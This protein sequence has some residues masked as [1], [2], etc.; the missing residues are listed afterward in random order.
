MFFE[1]IFLKILSFFLLS[2]IAIIIWDVIVLDLLIEKIFSLILVFFLLAFWLLLNGLE[3]LPLIILLLYVGAIAV[4]CLFVVILLNQKLQLRSYLTQ[5]HSMLKTLLSAELNFNFLYINFSSE[6]CYWYVDDS[7]DEPGQFL[8]NSA[9]HRCLDDAKFTNFRNNYL[10]DAEVREVFQFF[11]ST[12]DLEKLS[13]WVDLNNVTNCHGIYTGD[14]FFMCIGLGI[15]CGTLLFSSVYL[16]F[17]VLQEIVNG[18]LVTTEDISSTT[19]M[20]TILDHNIQVVRSENQWFSMDIEQVMV[21]R[22]QSLVNVV[23]LENIHTSLIT[24]P[25]YFHQMY[26]DNRTIFRGNMFEYSNQSSVMDYH[27]FRI[28]IQRLSLGQYHRVSHDFMRQITASEIHTNADHY[29]YQNLVASFSAGNEEAKEEFE[30]IPGR[31]RPMNLYFRSDF[32][33]IYF[34][35]IENVANVNNH[36]MLSIPIED[37]LDNRYYAGRFGRRSG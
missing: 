28:N 12:N 7:T 14:I 17:P 11:W 22:E 21:P 33:K 37:P 3:G 26:T 5:Q 34:F 1:L 36:A 31:F 8:C 24:N 19:N 13:L 4:L 9:L 29:E 6:K 18:N 20:V 32:F 23:L 35:Y 30:S 15:L 2:M 27:S 25:E 16:L 10:H